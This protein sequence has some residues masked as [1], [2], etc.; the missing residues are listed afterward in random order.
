[1][2]ETFTKIGT[3]EM[4]NQIPEQR[5]K[6][7]IDQYGSVRLFIDGNAGC[8]LLGL[9]LQEGEAEFVEVGPHLKDDTASS[10]ERRAMT[11]ALR[12]L[13]ER[14]GGVALPYAFC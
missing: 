7:L 9:N 10:P 1:M 8:A 2:S 5:W 11:Q 6:E 14:C 3:P 4:S 12:K 13:K